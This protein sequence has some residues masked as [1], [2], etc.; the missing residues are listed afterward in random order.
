MSAL[1]LGE[2]DCPWNIIGYDRD[3]T[4]STATAFASPPAGATAVL[5]QAETQNIR[6]TC[7]GTTPTSTVGLLV[8]TTDT[9]VVIT[10]DIAK[11]K[12]IEVSASAAVSLT[13]L[14]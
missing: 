8:K 1:I 10:G 13:Y 4:I 2:E 3:S 6:V 9:G 7:D 14:G 12:V 5:I 11:L